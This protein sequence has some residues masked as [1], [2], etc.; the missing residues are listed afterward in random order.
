M[1]IR[2][3]A[4]MR[5]I[6]FNSELEDFA[7]TLAKSNKITVEEAKLVIRSWIDWEEVAYN[8]EENGNA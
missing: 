2:G 5:E 3:C 8:V 6:K 7:Q 1:R 4:A